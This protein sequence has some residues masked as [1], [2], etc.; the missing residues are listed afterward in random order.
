MDMA[1][2]AITCRPYHA[3]SFSAAGV[4]FVVKYIVWVPVAGR[5]NVAALTS[6][7]R[8]ET[9]GNARAGMIDTLALGRSGSRARRYRGQH[10]CDA[11]HGQPV[12]LRHRAS[13]N[14]ALRAWGAARGLT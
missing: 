13:G 7:V 9:P 6:V 5:A 14:G 4:P 10:R 1:A 8:R 12:I 2:I 11:I 3:Q